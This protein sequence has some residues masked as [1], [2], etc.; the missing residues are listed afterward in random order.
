[1]SIARVEPVGNYAVQLVFSDGHDTG[2]FSFDLLYEYGSTQDRMWADYLQ[3]L[4]IGLRLLA[5]DPNRTRF[6]ESTELHGWWSEA[7]AVLKS[8][9]PIGVELRSEFPKDECW[10]AMS[11]PA[12]MQAVF[13][14]VQNA[15]DAMRDLPSGSVTVKAMEHD[16]GVDIVVSDTGPGM[17]EDVKRRCME[18]F[19]TTKAREIS[20]GLG[21]ALVY[22]IVRDAGGSVELDSVPGQG[23]TFT[24]RL[25]RGGKL[26]AVVEG[27]RRRAPAE[28][29]DAA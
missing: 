19:Y 2:I 12:L 8:T 14:L 29:R 7:V 26:P 24:L 11:R 17:S 6:A 13:N 23:T 9:L 1:M 3:R 16:E 10:V 4:A 27:A 22:G 15:G 21:L 20:T 18:P 5:A 25:L 28:G